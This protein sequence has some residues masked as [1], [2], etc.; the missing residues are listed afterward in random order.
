MQADASLAHTTLLLRT[1]LLKLWPIGVSDQLALTLG[2]CG[3]LHSPNE[4]VQIAC[5]RRLAPLAIQHI[6]S[7]SINEVEFIT[8]LKSASTKHSSLD[9]EMERSEWY[10]SRVSAAERA[11]ACTLAETS[12]AAAW[13]RPFIRLA[14][15]LAFEGRLPPMATLDAIFGAVVRSDQRRIDDLHF[16]A[17][18]GHPDALALLQSIESVCRVVI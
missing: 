3:I 13:R 7:I 6:H 5:D 4:A 14:T 8:I 2:L 17:S 11:L 1:K 18:N 15:A 9:P 16:D 10:S 12:G